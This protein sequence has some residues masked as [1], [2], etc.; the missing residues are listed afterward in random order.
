M[1][2]VVTD[3][4][5]AAGGEVESAVDDHFFARG[6]AECFGPFEFTGVTLHFELE[7]GEC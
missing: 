3:G 4:N 2:T 7:R 5:V 6:F 1:L